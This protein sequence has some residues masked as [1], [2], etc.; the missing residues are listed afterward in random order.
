MKIIT[1]LFAIIYSFACLAQQPDFINHGNH[2]FTPGHAAC[3]SKE[4]HNKV[5]GLVIHKKDSVMA[6]RRTARPANHPQF[7]WPVTQQDG[8]NYHNTWG[9]SNF[10]DHA[11]G[12]PNDIMD[13]NCGDR[14]YDLSNGYNHAGTDIFLWP[15]PWLQMQRG[16]NNVVAAAPG[17][18]LYKNDGQYDANCAMSGADWNAVYL[19]H[20]DGSVSWYGHLKRSSLTEKPIGASVAAGEFLGKIGS[21]GSSTGPHLH[22]EV[23]DSNNQLIDPFSGEC[24]DTNSESW[25]QEQIPYRSTTINALLTHNV[26]PVADACRDYTNYE[27]SQFATGT[28]VYLGLYLKD[29]TLGDIINLKVIR[30]N[31]T[32]YNDFNN[33]ATQTYN[34]SYWY[35]SFI[36]AAEG[37]WT[38]QAEY[39]GE[40]YTHQFTVGTMGIGAQPQQL[41]AAVYPNPAKETITIEA[42]QTV[43]HLSI[44][45]ST[46]KLLLQE[47]NTAGIT[48]SNV[49]GLAQ[50]IYFV[51]LTSIGGTSTTIKLQHI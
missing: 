16:Q 31:G 4:E 25:W 47:Q 39:M 15:F 36:P 18:I 45:D 12:Y 8:F 22:F 46:G 2:A 23:Y 9:I 5:Q 6:M 42:A 41:Q 38:W 27:V 3:I 7:I 33:V 32:V 35:W 19:L 28:R 21:S 17:T 30:P 14:S 1:T 37:N 49:S 50:G 11:S 51:K 48:T 10:V 13:Y 44:Y 20:A 29:Q 24:N 26:P 40:T 43:T 34:A